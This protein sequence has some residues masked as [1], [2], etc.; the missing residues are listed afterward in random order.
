MTDLVVV[1]LLEIFLI[2]DVVVSAAFSLCTQA[3]INADVSTEGAKVP[4]DSV[5]KAFLRNVLL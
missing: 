2:D 4:N 5:C 3:V 1:L